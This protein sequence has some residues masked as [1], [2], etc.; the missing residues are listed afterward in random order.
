MKLQQNS[1]DFDHHNLILRQMALSI[2]GV[3]DLSDRYQSEDLEK[4]LSHFQGMYME[5]GDALMDIR[6]KNNRGSV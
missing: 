4:I 1:L 5:L 2:A 3:R 6:V